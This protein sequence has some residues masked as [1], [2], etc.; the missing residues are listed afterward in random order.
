MCLLMVLLD[1]YSEMWPAAYPTTTASTPQSQTD[2]TLAT[3]PHVDNPAAQPT[4]N[5]TL[6]VGTCRVHAHMHTTTHARAH[7]H[8]HTHTHVD[9]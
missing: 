3:L 4:G 7:T 6:L 5:V 8:T 1:R 9:T 2:P